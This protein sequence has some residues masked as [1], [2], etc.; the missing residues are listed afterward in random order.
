MS[1][2]LSPGDARKGDVQRV[3][4]T[5]G[6]MTVEYEIG[7][8]CCK[9]FMQPVPQCPQFMRRYRQMFLR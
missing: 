9:S 3:G 4:Q 2:Q 5:L 7:N 8:S 6:R 1:Q